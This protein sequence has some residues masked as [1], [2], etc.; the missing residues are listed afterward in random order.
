MTDTQAIESQDITVGGVFQAFYAVPDYQREYVWQTAQVEQLLSDILSEMPA[1]PSEAPPAEYF[2]GSIVVCPNASGVLDLID[3][4]QRMTTLFVTLCAIRDRLEALRDTVETP[5]NGQLSSQSMDDWGNSRHRYR[6][7]LQYEDAQGV[8][9]KLIGREQAGAK[10]G[11]N[12][13][14]NIANAYTTALQFLTRELGD[15]AD[16]CAPSTPTSSIA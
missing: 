3:G 9:A 11:T 12:S 6:L 8:L 10:F 16:R 1:K 14:E 13:A 4:Q 15:D 5:I 7:D 2:I